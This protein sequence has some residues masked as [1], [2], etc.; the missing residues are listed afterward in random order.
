MM[1]VIAGCLLMLLIGFAYGVISYRGQIFPF[2][3]MRRLVHPMTFVPP[4]ESLYGTRVDM[5]GRFQEY[6]RVLM[7]G[8]SL[9][10]WGRWSAMF[11]CESIVNHGITG[12]TTTGALARV[13]AALAVGANSIFVMLGINDL[14]YLDTS[15][16]I[17]TRYILLLEKFKRTEANI[18][19]Q[20]I[21]KVNRDQKLNDRISAI[22]VRLSFYC[23]EAGCK[24]I[25]L[26]TAMAESGSLDP[27][28]TYDGVHLT[29]AGY[30]VWRVALMPYMQQC[31]AK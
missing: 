9:T 11:P 30:D 12:E 23:K 25:D 19:V 26:N 2:A 8:D 28:Y 24:F 22:N 6:G 17:V 5:L 29:A 20:S 10:E 14:D 7:I 27:R 21:L 18:F 31:R 4:R 3:L 15:E 13:D 16:S 1:R